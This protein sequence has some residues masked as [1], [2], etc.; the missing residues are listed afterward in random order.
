MQVDA[1][2]LLLLSLFAA[3]SSG[4]SVPASVTGAVDSTSFT[5]GSSVA[6]LGTGPSDSQS[7]AILIAN[8][9][10]AACEAIPDQTRSSDLDL[11]TL[12]VVSASTVAPGTYAINIGGSGNVLAAGQF[13]TTRAECVSGITAE[14]TSGSITVVTVDKLRV[15]GS[16]SVAFGSRGSFSGTFDV[17]VC[18]ASEGGQLAPDAAEPSCQP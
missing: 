14:A 10:S 9:S 7:L 1:V 15:S 17:P 12:T 13:V 8:N 4:S 5:V 18:S 6:L 3:C 16:Y 11:L 2:G